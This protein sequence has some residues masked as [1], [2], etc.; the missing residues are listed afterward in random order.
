VGKKNIVVKL[1]QAKTGSNPA[2]TSKENNG[3]GREVL[4]L[5]MMRDVVP[6]KKLCNI[7]YLIL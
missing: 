7:I 1:K 3:S 4:L 5:M 2:E 6:C